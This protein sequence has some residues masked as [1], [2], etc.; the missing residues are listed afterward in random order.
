MAK[1]FSE[2]ENLHFVMLRYIKGKAENW[3]VLDP[4]NFEITENVEMLRL[5][6]AENK[7]KRLKIAYY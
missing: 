6:T 2:A 7:Q 3:R 1:Y 4:E 5:K